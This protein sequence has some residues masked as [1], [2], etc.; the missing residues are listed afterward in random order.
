MPF[1][2]EKAIAPRK[3]SNGRKYVKYFNSVKK[4]EKIWIFQEVTI[5]LR[6][7]SAV[8]QLK[9]MMIFFLF[10]TSLRVPAQY[11]LKW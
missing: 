3:V 4:F 11:I 9:N 5:D 8:M 10:E 2:M 7:K 1:L 6:K